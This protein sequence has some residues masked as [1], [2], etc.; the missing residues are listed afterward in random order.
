MTQMSSFYATRHPW[1]WA[2]DISRNGKYLL[3]GSSDRI[4]RVWNMETGQELR[5]IPG[6]GAK[7]DQGFM[8]SGCPEGVTG[9]SFC[10]D[11]RRFV[12]CGDDGA[13]SLWDIVSGKK[14]RSFRGHSGPVASVATSRDG[15]T[16]LSGAEH[17]DGRIC[18]WDADNGTK[19]MSMPCIAGGIQ[20]LARSPD[21]AYAVSGEG[22]A[23]I[24]LRDL[25]T[26]KVVRT[27]QQ[28][29]RSQII[30]CVA[31]SPDG[32]SVLS[33]GGHER[34]I[35]LW[36]V[37]TGK[38]KWNVGSGE[39]PYWAAFAPNGQT[40]LTAVYDEHIRRLDALSGEE[41]Q[42]FS[43]RSPGSLFHRVLFSRDGRIA[44]AASSDLTVLHI[45]DLPGL[46]DI[47]EECRWPL[48]G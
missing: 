2:L 20:S 25:R 30:S 23:M 16:I 3:S 41:I 34:T 12:S 32:K 6:H 22:D 42:R 13:I 10:S 37:N 29:Y 44:I 28:A 43:H 18:L 24:V 47:P 39:Y 26:K 46:H 17:P 5:T 33:L 35:Y 1:F 31:F 7:L 40:I 9:V 48:P 36:D 14:I 19:L 27:F 38:V 4:I 15:R 45:P 8:K 11:N 21:G